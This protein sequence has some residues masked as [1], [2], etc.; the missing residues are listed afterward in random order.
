MTIGHYNTGSY[1]AKNHINLFFST[2]EWPAENFEPYLYGSL[3]NTNPDVA[4]KLVN[5]EYTQANIV[6]LKIYFE[7][8]NQQ[9]RL[10]LNSN[11]S[12]FFEVL[13]EEPKVT[14]WTMMSTIGGSMGLYIGVSVITVAEVV[15]LIIKLIRQKNCC[16]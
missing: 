5:Q 7:E 1:Q 14:F 12:K 2:L 4:K 15:E 11:S 8:L 3:A 9:G 10:D 6:E 16:A 13:E